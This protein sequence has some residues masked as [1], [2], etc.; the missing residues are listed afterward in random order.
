MFWLPTSMYLI[1]IQL[2][3]IVTHLHFGIIMITYNRVLDNKLL[4]KII[5]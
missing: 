4:M 3:S 1:H 2:S 5:M